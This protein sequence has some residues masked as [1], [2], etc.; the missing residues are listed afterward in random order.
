MEH[1]NGNVNCEFHA[2][3]IEFVFVDD[4]MWIAVMFAFAFY[5]ALV[6]LPPHGELLHGKL[7]PV[8]NG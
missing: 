3:R 7:I 6:L 5:R 4:S 2:T 1:D 8:E